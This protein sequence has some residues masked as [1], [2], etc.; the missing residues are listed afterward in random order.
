[1]ADDGP[2]QAATAPAATA[3]AGR[4]GG[5]GV[6]EAAAKA[7]KP[8]CRICNGKE[9]KVDRLMT[10]CS[11]CKGAMEFIHYK[12]LLKRY[13]EK[14]RWC[15]LACLDCDRLYSPDIS[16]KLG[17]IGLQAMEKECKK[18]QFK[19]V[20]MLYAMG[21]AYGRVKE[22][23]RQLPLFERALEIVE[24]ACGPDGEL[25]KKA[26]NA[27]CT[28]LT[29]LGVCC[30]SLNEPL[31]QRDLLLRALAITERNYGK[32]DLE[33]ATVLT[34][35]GNAYGRL[36]DAENQREIMRRALDIQERKL[37]EK[38]KALLMTMSGLAAAFEATGDTTGQLELLERILEI[39]EQEF[40][41]GHH[42]AAVTLTDLA[43]C[44]GKKGKDDKKVELLERALEIMEQTYGAEHKVVAV[45]LSNLGIAYGA[46]GQPKK[47]RE[48]LERAL[49]IEEK[50][51]GKN[52][53]ELAV[54]LIGLADAWEK[55]G[56]EGKQK[57][58]LARSRAITE[59]AEK[60]EKPQE[61]KSSKKKGSEDKL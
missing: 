8:V 49:A 27:V 47:Q 45:T 34:N 28:A 57:S 60:A 7:Q 26:G 52:S 22:F 53:I 16:L 24:K 48:L 35:L 58:F 23:K 21:N 39:K 44:Y 51:F 4:Q 46:I 33:T 42:W 12:C 30:A 25:D 13:K 56:N 38:N 10:P 31:C 43:L 17:T 1:M 40:G 9:T 19:L 55:L 20:P 36:G 11:G 61:R 15:P 5:P 59:K 29:N 18:V 6:E 14:A 50:E 41:P 3:E 2:T 37:G 54:T 32:R